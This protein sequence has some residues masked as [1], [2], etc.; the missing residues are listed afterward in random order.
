ML[1]YLFGPAARPFRSAGPRCRP[2][3]R[4]AAPACIHW[5]DRVKPWHPQ[6]TPERDRWRAYATR[7]RNRQ[8]V[9]VPKA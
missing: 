2:A 1:Q 9:A 6:L 8:Q 4:S 3:R 7:Y 5:A